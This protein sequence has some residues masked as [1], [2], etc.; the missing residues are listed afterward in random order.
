VTSRQEG[1]VDYLVCPVGSATSDANLG[2]MGETSGSLGHLVKAARVR[3][4]DLEL[5]WSNGRAR[6]VV[7]CL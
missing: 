1:A 4:D 7:S 3:Q 2:G 6:L 5:I